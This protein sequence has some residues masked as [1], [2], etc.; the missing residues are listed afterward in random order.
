LIAFA[1]M[2]ASVVTGKTMDDSVEG[3][4]DF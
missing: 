4:L 2:A 1:K 3:N